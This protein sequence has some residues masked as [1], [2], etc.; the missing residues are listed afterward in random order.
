MRKKLEI[1]EEAKSN[2][3]RYAAALLAVLLI[4][5]VLIAVQGAVSYTHLDVYKRQM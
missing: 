1:N 4:G 5:A 2:L 3:I